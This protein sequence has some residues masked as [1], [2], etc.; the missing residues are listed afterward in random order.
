MHYVI[1]VTVKADARAHFFFIRAY[2]H[3]HISSKTRSKSN[4]STLFSCLSFFP[5]DK[6]MEGVRALVSNLLRVA[7]I[8]QAYIFERGNAVKK[9]FAGKNKFEAENVISSGKSE[10][11]TPFKNETFAAFRT[12][13]FLDYGRGKRALNEESRKLGGSTLRGGRSLLLVCKM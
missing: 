6:Y 4:N 2:I 11:E 10:R 1:N 9:P 12:A 3:T 13:S 7:F 8:V 5:P